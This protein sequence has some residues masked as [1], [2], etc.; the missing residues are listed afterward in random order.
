MS[1]E[2]NAVIAD[3]MREAVQESEEAISAAGQIDRR[4]RGARDGRR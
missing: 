2:T 3:K 1:D 4:G